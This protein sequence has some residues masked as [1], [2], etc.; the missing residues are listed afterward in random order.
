MIIGGNMRGPSFDLSLK[1]LAV[2]WST[3]PFCSVMADDFAELG[4]GNQQPR[5]N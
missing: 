4:F 5:P 3:V 1:G 2:H